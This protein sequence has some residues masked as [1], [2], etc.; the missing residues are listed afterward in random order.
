VRIQRRQRQDGL[1]NLFAAEEADMQEVT[2]ASAWC[3]GEVRDLTPRRS[4]NTTAVRPIDL[5]RAQA[6][7]GMAPSTSFFGRVSIITNE[8]QTITEAHG[9]VGVQI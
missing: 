1:D 5:H 7:Q 6:K 2:P 3:N 9:F 8:C 4:R